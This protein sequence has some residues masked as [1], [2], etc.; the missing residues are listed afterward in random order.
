[1]IP[2]FSAELTPRDQ[3]DMTIYL[4]MLNEQ[5]RDALL[6][7]VRYAAGISGAEHVELQHLDPAGLLFRVSEGFEQARWAEVPF[8]RR[9]GSLRAMQNEVVKLLFR[10]RTIAGAGVPI[11]RLETQH[12]RSTVLRVHRGEV[13]ARRV[14]TPRVFSLTLRTAPNSFTTPGFDAFVFLCAPTTPGGKTLFDQGFNM[15]EYRAL[16]EQQRPAGA[17]MTVRAVR[18]DEIDIWCVQ[19]NGPARGSVAVVDWAWRARQGDRVAFWGP[20]T[21]FEPPPGSKRV[22]LVADEAA[23]PA[24]LGIVETLSPGV[25]VCLLAECANPDERLPVPDRR[26]LDVHWC[27]RKGSP[28]GRSGALQ[29]SC[30]GLEFDPEGLY[31]FGGGEA[32]EMSRL[33]RYLSRERSLSSGQI[34]LAGYWR[35]DLRNGVNVRVWQR[36]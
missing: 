13:L 19:H 35:D 9:A 18:E 12:A 30:A 2:E 23:L 29:R 17:H 4:T 25:P 31:V 7:I 5:H 15:A 26:N 1:M 24:A 20:R 11:T 28:A 34:Q 33:G 14:L 36:Q 6:L 32:Q 3:A 8:E 22:L 10:A 21:A 27:Y 16:P